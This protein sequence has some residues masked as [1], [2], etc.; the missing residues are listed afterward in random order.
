MW[1]HGRQA[2]PGRFPLLATHP[3]VPTRDREIARL[4][5]LCLTA[6]V[7]TT[8]VGASGLGGTAGPQES[9]EVVRAQLEL[10]ICDL[11]NAGT[12]DAVS[13][14]LG[15]G[16]ITWL[17]RPGP[18]L[19]RGKR[20]IYDLL[21]DGVHRLS[22]IDR[23]E[24]S[25]PGNDDL[26]LRELRFIVNGRAIFVRTY[27]GGVWL[28]SMPRHALENSAAE[29]RANASWQTYSW[30]MPEWITATGAT[31]S[32]NELTERL[33]SC[34]ASAIHDAG[35]SW[36][37]A[38][39]KPIDLR[40]KDDSTVS[41]DVVLQRRMPY[42]VN[43]RL[44]LSFDVSLCRAEQPEATISN[45]ELREVRHWYTATTSDNERMLLTLQRRL[46]RARPLVVVGGIC[47]HFDRSMSVSY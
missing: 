4:Q 47:P 8:L 13:A 18:D 25:K 28:D 16:V 5:A 15:M 21:L 14:T 26:C 9:T 35:L 45:V 40:R 1:R 23:L 43:R 3:I 24:I 6:L 36:S 12:D 34:V 38:R 10:S 31:M 22:D 30:S 42:W 33:M 27:P 44:A 17:D 20:Y 37:S 41:V 11:R 32:R 29:L 39:E 19:E 2:Q 7:F 46:M